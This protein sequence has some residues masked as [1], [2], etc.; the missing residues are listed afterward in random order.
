[1][2]WS[3]T[4]FGDVYVISDGMGGH[5]GGAKAAELT[6][7]T[8][9]ESLL[10]ASLQDGDF[11]AQVREAFSAANE[12][13]RKHR[14]PDDPNTREMGATAVMLIT[15]GDRFMVAHVGD[16]R[17]YL[18]RPWYFGLKR[19]TRDHTRAQE[20]ADRKVI[21]A[22][23]ADSHPDASMLVRAM[24]H[25]PTVE[26][27]ISDWQQIQPGEMLLL[28]S[29]GLCGYVSDREIR[30]S[31]RSGHDPRRITDALIAKA[32]K[33]GG[34]DNVTVQLL[35]YEPPQRGRALTAML[36]AC[37]A[38]AVAAATGWELIQLDQH[39]K[40]V[41]EGVS[42][43]TQEVKKIAALPPAAPPVIEAPPPPSPSLT[44]K[45]KPQEKQKEIGKDK[46]REKAAATANSD[47]A[48]AN[49]KASE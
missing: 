29:D 20:L 27:D 2:G 12:T 4:S 3:R 47:A 39:L 43:L 9:Q 32:L 24:G 16:S 8:L 11:K 46:P 14:N 33:K 49:E 41:G 7:S 44:L 34:E 10:H 17:A 19:L 38:L 25:A 35:R 26:V 5:R 6:I 15:Q 22:K 21:P 37:I 23:E 28:C 18:W 13:V 1:M 48:A 30:S 31:L 36:L 45:Q 42:S 40:K